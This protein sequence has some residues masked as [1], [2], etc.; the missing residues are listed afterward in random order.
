L[1]IGSLALLLLHQQQASVGREGMKVI[2]TIGPTPTEISQI[3]NADLLVKKSQ[4]RAVIS[5]S[6]YMEVEF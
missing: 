1:A 5:S 6:G 2:L 3:A 4:M